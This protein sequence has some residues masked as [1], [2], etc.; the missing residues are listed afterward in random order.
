MILPY[1]DIAV[2]DADDED[3]DPS[4][5]EIKTE[6]DMENVDGNITNSNFVQSLTLLPSSH[7]SVSKDDDVFQ[8]KLNQEHLREQ[9]LQN[10]SYQ[11]R[12]HHEYF[13][14]ERFHQGPTEMTTANGPNSN[15]A[16]SNYYNSVLVPPSHSRGSDQLSFGYEQEDKEQED[17]E[18]EDQEQ[19]DQEQED[20]EQD[21]Q[22][23]DDKEQDDKEQDE[24]APLSHK[25]S[26]K[27]IHRSW[28][29]RQRGKAE[30]PRFE[31]V[32][33]VRRCSRRFKDKIGLNIHHSAMHPDQP[34]PFAQPAPPELPYKC[35][36][37][38]CS[39]SFTTSS[40]LGNHLGRSHPEYRRDAESARLIRCRVG[41]CLETFS[42]KSAA[43]IHHTQAHSNIIPNPW[44]NQALETVFTCKVPNCR[45][46]TKVPGGLRKHYETAHPDFNPD[47]HEEKSF[48]HKCTVCGQSFER[49]IGLTLH[50][51]ALHP[52]PKPLAPSLRFRC[53]FPFCT[54]SF[55]REGALKNHKRVAH[56]KS[57]S[58]E[59]GMFFCPVLGCRRFFDRPGSLAAHITHSHPGF[60]KRNFSLSGTNVI[61]QLN[62]RNSVRNQRMQNLR[63]L[64]SHKDYLSKDKVSHS[65]QLEESDGEGSEY[66]PSKG[67]PGISASKIR[68]QPNV[69]ARRPL[70]PDGLQKE[71]P[72]QPPSGRTFSSIFGKTPKR[73]PV[74]IEMAGNPSVEVE[75]SMFVTP[76]PEC[77]PSRHSEKWVKTEDTQ[78]ERE[79]QEELYGVPTPSPR[80]RPTNSHATSPTLTDLFTLSTPSSVEPSIPQN[81]RI[82]R[83]AHNATRR[84]G[85]PKPGKTE[86]KKPFV[87]AKCGNSYKSLAQLC[88]HLAN[89]HLIWLC[90]VPDCNCY[91]PDNEPLLAHYYHY[92]EQKAPRHVQEGGLFPL[93]VVEVAEKMDLSGEE[94]ESELHH[95]FKKCKQK[96]RVRKDLE[97]SEATHNYQDEHIAIGRQY[98][99]EIL[100]QISARFHAAQSSGHPLEPAIDFRRATN[101]KEPK[102]FSSSQYDDNFVEDSF[103]SQGYRL[104]WPSDVMLQLEQRETG[105]KVREP[106]P[107]QR[108]GALRASLCR[109]SQPFQASLSTKVSKDYKTDA[110]RFPHRFQSQLQNSYSLESLTPYLFGTRGKSTNP[111]RLPN[112]NPYLLSN[113]DTSSV[114]LRLP[115]ANT[116]SLS[117][118]TTLTD[119]MTYQF[120]FSKGE[121]SN[122]LAT[123][124]SG[125]SSKITRKHAKKDAK[126]KTKEHDK[127]LLPKTSVYHM[128]KSGRK[129]IR[130]GNRSVTIEE[131][132]PSTAACTAPTEAELSFSIEHNTPPI[133]RVKKYA[134]SVEI[135]A[136]CGDL[137]MG[138]REEF[139]NTNRGSSAKRKRANDSTTTAP[140][141]KGVFKNEDEEYD[142]NESEV[143][144]R[145]AE[146]ES[147][148]R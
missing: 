43:S 20:Q 138:G 118:S 44:N 119:A 123:S 66:R 110:Q 49:S 115:P 68:R 39:R 108:K 146:P 136:L 13:H 80:I 89:S 57:E 141:K 87:C 92:H 135:R 114:H 18:Q 14:P 45:K 78:G 124:T 61:S 17:Q 29:K 71:T 91:F 86:D 25:E 75:T 19:E 85:S 88:R 5:E 72:P 93:E 113:R 144:D 35:T 122:E 52:E 16:P 74:P 6:T 8:E 64:T 97:E 101:Q 28:R 147:H 21:D 125:P 70:F 100:P 48:P 137:G 84:G 77:P 2:A 104:D 27:S 15:P 11:E 94:N 1:E 12:F 34:R 127:A 7:R 55:D 24:V 145:G 121:A 98:P 133:D 30:N 9:I 112:K 33:Q 41:G 148:Y 23:Q 139:E 79:L 120:A 53:N 60:D 65:L 105:T 126:K 90:A 73:Q 107:S 109:E 116:R 54:R 40:G 129:V 32:C 81:F 82:I 22:E 106:S 51:T 134:S 26:G 99:S 59:D 38:G 132:P 46:T 37:P 96:F 128:T 111:H 142:G 131:S 50:I 130:Q 67:I 47:D 76:A 143:E 140:R 69:G 103:N 36:L 31:Y 102:N 3:L 95:N 63:P 117:P 83:S 10:Q 62:D 56:P 42:T 58:E 4:R